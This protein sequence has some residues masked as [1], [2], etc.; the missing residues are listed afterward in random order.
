MSREEMVEIRTDI[1][2]IKRTLGNL[3]KLMIALLG[4]CAAIGCTGLATCRADLERD[5]AM[6]A[7]IEVHE[8]QLHELSSRA[9]S[10]MTLSKR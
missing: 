10:T 7:R 4:V 1:A 2:W 8:A 6:S 5:A 3:N 9:G